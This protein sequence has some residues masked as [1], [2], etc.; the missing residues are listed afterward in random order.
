MNFRRGR[1]IL[2][3][4]RKKEETEMKY[5]LLLGRIFFA[6]IDKGK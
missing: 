1:G 6:L 2:K 4:E 5:I 3:E